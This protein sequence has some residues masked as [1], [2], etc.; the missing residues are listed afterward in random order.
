MWR[1]SDRT[2]SSLSDAAGREDT[3]RG[4]WGRY[5]I[6]FDSSGFALKYPLGTSRFVWDE[7]DGD[8]HARTDNTVDFNIRSDSR[9]RHTAVFLWLTR[10]S[11]AQKGADIQIRA[12]SFGMS[13]VQLAAALNARRAERLGESASTADREL[14]PEPSLRS[15]PWTRAHFRRFFSWLIPLALAAYLLERFVR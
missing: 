15:E 9:K 14:T 7:V 6:A 13:A 1:K 3:T 5:V 11:R 8:F 12:D 4:S 2:P 10:L